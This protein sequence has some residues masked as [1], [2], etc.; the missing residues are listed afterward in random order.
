MNLK[1]KFTPIAGDA[2]PSKYDDW[3]M[4]GMCLYHILPTQEG[5]NLWHEWSARADNYDATPLDVKWASFGKAEPLPAV[6]AQIGTT[7]AIVNKLHDIMNDPMWA[8]HCTVSKK[9]LLAVSLRL[10]TFDAMVSE[11]RAAESYADQKVEQ[12]EAERDNLL[13][14]L[15]DIAVD[16]RRFR[17]MA[18]LTEHMMR[19]IH[20]DPDDNAAKAMV[21]IN[22]MQPSNLEELRAAFDAVMV[23]NLVP[24]APAK[25]INGVEIAEKT[26]QDG[27]L[28]SGR[29]VRNYKVTDL[30]DYSKCKHCFYVMPSQRDP[31]DPLIEIHAPGCVVNLAR[32]FIENYKDAD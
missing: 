24:D 13:T 23:E 28:I 5:L 17:T 9:F 10:E 18:W 19:E 26:R 27:L 3:I 29:L 2:D 7:E 16:G 15:A 6:H 12:L 31:M 25:W 32:Q 21:I 30:H 11:A 22:S 1:D 20:L 14:T 8:D 4:I